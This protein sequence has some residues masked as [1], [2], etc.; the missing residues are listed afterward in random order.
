MNKI[1]RLI[2][3]AI[4]NL[5]ILG[6]FQTFFHMYFVYN[7]DLFKDYLYSFG[8]P[9]IVVFGFLQI[10]IAWFALS[11]WILTKDWTPYLK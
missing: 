9:I 4:A 7:I 3:K 2:I 5:S 8:E 10:I 6:L 11:L 1:L